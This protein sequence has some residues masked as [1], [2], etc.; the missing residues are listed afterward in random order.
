MKIGEVKSITMDWANRILDVW[1]GSGNFADRMVKPAIKVMLKAN[2]DK[3]DDILVAFTK[4]DGTIMMNELIDSYINE[5]P[6]EGLIL[7]VTDFIGDN[8]FARAISP[9]LLERSDLVELKRRL[10]NA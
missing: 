1:F 4:K 10:S 2:I 6:E 9:K 3:M 7:N 8:A 5:I